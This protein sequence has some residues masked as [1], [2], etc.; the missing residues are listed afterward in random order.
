MPMWLP[1]NWR[2]MPNANLAAAIREL[3]CV[4]TFDNDNL[5]MPFLFVA[6]FSNRR[7]TQL[8]EPVPP[9]LKRL[10]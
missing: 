5:K 9:W 10:L 2:W 6:S 7:V 3:P 4:L 8:N 1:G